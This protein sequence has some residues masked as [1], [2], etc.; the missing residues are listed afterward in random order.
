MAEGDIHRQL[1]A[2]L[3]N[4]VRTE[5]AGTWHVFVDGIRVFGDGGPPPNLGDVRPD[6]YAVESR[7]R[8]III[9]EAKCASDIDNPHTEKQLL[10]YFQHLAGCSAGRLA[11]S[12]PL[13]SAGTAHR[14]CRC[15]RLR[16]GA[17][18]IPF[19][20]FGWL[21]GPNPISKVWRG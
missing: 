12:V 6:L 18:H 2:C 3:S 14:I 17:G 16:A 5:Q 15:V 19:E 8:Y 1:V 20:V 13:F 4:V 21:L 10:Q 7:S 11:L 9:G